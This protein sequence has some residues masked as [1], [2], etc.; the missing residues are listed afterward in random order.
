[1]MPMTL[2]CWDVIL[3]R[4]ILLHCKMLM[5]GRNGNSY[6]GNVNN[7]PFTL[8]QMQMTVQVCVTGE[9]WR[10][11]GTTFWS[12]ESIRVRD[13]VPLLGCGWPELWAGISAGA[14]LFPLMA[15]TSC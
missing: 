12:S 2:Y 9:E 11:T 8:L 13:A 6:E 4:V 1:M 15:D 5:K 3:P 7:S 14:E 10:V